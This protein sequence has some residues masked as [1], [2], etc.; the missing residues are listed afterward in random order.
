MGDRKEEDANAAG[1]KDKLWFWP[2]GGGGVAEAA[3]AV[4]QR[5]HKQ[6]S[7]KAS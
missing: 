6:K 4:E 3:A 1:E 5:E 7:D 2:L